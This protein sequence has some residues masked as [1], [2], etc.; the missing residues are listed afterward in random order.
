VIR[1]FHAPPSVIHL[2]NVYY[3]GV[4]QW[5]IYDMNP[6]PPPDLSVTLNYY[7][8]AWQRLISGAVHHDELASLIET[9]FSSEKVVDRVN[10]LQG[11]D[12]Q[13]FIDV[14]DAVWHHAFLPPENGSI[15][16]LVRHWMAMISSR[17][18]EGNP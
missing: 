8:Q 14:L 17:T 5:R 16:P 2:L 3:A 12:V 10:R 9:I 13:T 15:Q 11:N 6:V 1:L 4:L 7:D 18:S